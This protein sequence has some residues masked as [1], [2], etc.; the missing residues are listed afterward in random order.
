MNIGIVT[1]WYPSGGGS[2]ARA[3]V[4]ALQAKHRVFVYARGGQPGSERKWDAPNVTWAPYHPCSTGIHRR[5]F[6]R[7]AKRLQIEAVLFN[8]QHH[9]VGVVLAKQLG[10]LTGAYVDYYT[11]ATVPF[12]DLYD[13]LI[14]NTRRHHGV[15]AQHPQCCY[16]PW[17]TRTGVYRPLERREPGPL[18]FLISAGWDGHYARNAPYMDRRGAGLAMRAF[19]LVKGDCRLIV[20]SQDSL[21]QCPEEWR[22]LLGTEPRIE[23]R[24]GTFDPTPYGVGDLYLYPSRLDGIGLTLPEA[25]SSG[26]PAITTDAPPMSEF[27]RHGVNGLLVP[28]REHRGRPD[29]YYWP[30]SLCD[31]QALAAACQSY[32]DAPEMVERH[33][34][35]ARELAEQD[36]DWERNA[37]FLPGWIAAQRRRSLDQPAWRA[38]AERA[39]R[40]D[41][42][43]SPTP[44]RRLRRGAGAALKQLLGMEQ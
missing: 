13:F 9:W 2:V 19:G 16:C 33:G 23:F 26:L 18:R 28:V 41:H 12:F 24:A 32:V 8:E 40:Y 43:H 37:A 15:F 22:S 34:A 6:E 21:D 20:L 11:Q 14:C 31:E 3:Y 4:G 35:R 39:L 10:L 42:E 27:V 17:G 1:T 5:H 36:L 25:L 29:G 30:E 38:M 44:M 7:W